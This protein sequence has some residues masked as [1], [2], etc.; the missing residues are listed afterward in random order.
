M[1]IYIWRNVE[2]LT[3]RWHDDGGFVAVAESL[4]AA[5]AMS[6]EECGARVTEPDAEY[7]LADGVPAAEFVFPD[8]GCC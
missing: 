1:K 3:T 7:E 8:S 4:E 5:R 2:K 6:P